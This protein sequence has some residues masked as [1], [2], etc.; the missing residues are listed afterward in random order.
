M[1][2]VAEISAPRVTEKGPLHFGIGGHQWPQ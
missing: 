1:V 2:D